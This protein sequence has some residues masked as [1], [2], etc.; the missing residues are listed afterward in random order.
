M[1]TVVVNV[2]LA[3]CEV[4]IHRRTIWGNPFIIGVHGDRKK[5]VALYETYIKS[6]PELLARLPELRGKA[7][8]CYCAPFA[9]HGDVLARLA[10]G[11]EA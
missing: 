1:N 11:E 4:P 6:K 7:L 8:G 9:C 10:D 3:E 2:L 5:V